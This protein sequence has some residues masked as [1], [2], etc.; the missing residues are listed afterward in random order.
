MDNAKGATV[1]VAQ[2]CG[3]SESTRLRLM[4]ALIAGSQLFDVQL[5]D[6][7]AALAQVGFNHKYVWVMTGQEGDRRK[8]ISGK[9]R[10]QCRIEY[11]NS[12]T[13]ASAATA[14][15]D[16]GGVLVLHYVDKHSDKEGSVKLR[17]TNDAVRLDFVLAFR[18]YHAM[19]LTDIAP[20]CVGPEVAHDWRKGK[21]EAY[22]TEQRNPSYPLK[23]LRVKPNC[24]HRM[25]LALERSPPT[26]M[27]HATW[28]GPLS[29][30]MSE[31]S[32]VKFTND[33]ALHGL[34]WIEARDILIAVMTA[35]DVQGPIAVG[36]N[37]VLPGPPCGS[38]NSRPA[39]RVHSPANNLNCTT[40]PRRR[41]SHPAISSPT[42]SSLPPLEL[43]TKHTG[44]ELHQQYMQL[45]RR[46]ADTAAKVDQL[47]DELRQQR[48]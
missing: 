33:V 32:I 42:L 39:L 40:P 9:F 23:F 20:E 29:K 3:L 44:P 6:P 43:A 18:L 1:E 28:K 4:E 31:E 19:S 25:R 14:K 45:A 30:P 11:N 12:T 2:M 36:S 38:L 24:H 16:G 34:G 15:S 47:Q 8:V 5:V 10:K 21:F 26:H 46:I 27:L 41:R 22:Q 35:D 17:V 37:S 48:Y 7:P 13:S